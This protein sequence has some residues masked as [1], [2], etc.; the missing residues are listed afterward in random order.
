[1]PS[2]HVLGVEPVRVRV[3]VITAGKV[4]VSTVMAGGLPLHFP[5]VATA[6]AAILREEFSLH[7]ASASIGGG[8][9]LIPSDWPAW[10][11]TPPRPPGA[12]GR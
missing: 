6:M 7:G 1:M 10:R 8:A 2:G 9:V 3:R 5:V 12:E 11:P 4:A